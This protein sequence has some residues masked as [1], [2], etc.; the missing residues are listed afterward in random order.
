MI[1]F[2]AAPAKGRQAVTK[3]ILRTAIIVFLPV[4]LLRAQASDPLKLE[5]TI[6]LP[7][8][9]GRIDHMSLDVKGERLFVCALGNNTVEVI[10]LK[11]GKRTNAISGLKEPQGALYVTA[12]DRLYIASSKDGTVKCLM[13]LRCSSSKPSSMETTRITFDTIPLAR[14]SMSEYLCD[15]RRRCHFRF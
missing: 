1:R 3:A 5:K 7:E 10:D 15:R 14:G 6:E 4:S 8:V 9:Q 11:T 13:G 2:Q 12:N